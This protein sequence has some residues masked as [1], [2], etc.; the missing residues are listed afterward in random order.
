MIAALVPCPACRRHIR[1]VETTCPFCSR[2][3]SQAS[4]QAV[5]PAM[6]G[7]LSRAALVALGTTLAGCSATTSSVDGSMSPDT[8]LA[9]ARTG[10]DVQPDLT[11]CC[12][13]YGHPIFDASTDTGSVDTGVDAGNI[14]PPYGIAPTDA[15]MPD[16]GT[17]AG[18][19]APPYG[20]APADV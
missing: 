10:T 19:I 9:D 1:A 14:A 8:P 5:R 18:N 12:P 11:N 3:V 2:A 16:T 4:A 6:T 17:D 20:I 7:R 13:P 15:G